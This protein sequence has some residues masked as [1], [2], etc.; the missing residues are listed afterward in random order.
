[1]SFHFVNVTNVLIYFGT[2]EAA[3]KMFRVYFAFRS[4]EIVY[5]FYLRNKFRV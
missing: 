4:G 5:V 1:M 3:L 2:S